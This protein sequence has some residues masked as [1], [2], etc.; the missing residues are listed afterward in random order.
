MLHC[1]GAGD[2]C[3]IPVPALPRP[4]IPPIS[5]RPTMDSTFRPAHHALSAWSEFRN[6]LIKQNVLALAIAVVIGAALNE[7]IKS[8][9][10]GLIMPII[11]ALSPAESYTAWTWT[12]GAAVFKPGLVVAALINFLIIGIVAW[13]LTKALI[14]PVAETATRPCPHCYTMVD[15]RASRCHSCTSELAPTMAA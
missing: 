7:V 3:S 5:E 11:G 13:R 14:K 2:S 15:A 8:L 4:A 12:I 6:F 10:D 1:A 9:V